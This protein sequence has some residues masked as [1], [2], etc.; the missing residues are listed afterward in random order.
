VQAGTMAV[1][2]VADTA[3]FDLARQRGRRY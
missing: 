2:A 1:M 3:S